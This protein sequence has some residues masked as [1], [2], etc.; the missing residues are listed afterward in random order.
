[1]VFPSQCGRGTKSSPD[2]QSLSSVTTLC[3]FYRKPHARVFFLHRTGS[4]MRLCRGSTL[5]CTCNVTLSKI[6]SSIISTLNRGQA[7]N[8]A[9]YGHFQDLWLNATSDNFCRGRQKGGFSFCVAPAIHYTNKN[10][11]LGGFRRLYTVART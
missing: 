3:K 6:V 8:R 1:M 7:E 5:R 9:T 10:C 2:R 11:P 4:I